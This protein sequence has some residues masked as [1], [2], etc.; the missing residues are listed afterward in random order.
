MIKST[1]RS[2]G[3]F[4][5]HIKHYESSRHA[6]AINM[7]KGSNLKAQAYNNLCIHVHFMTA[8]IYTPGK[9]VSQ[10]P[11]L[12]IVSMLPLPLSNMCM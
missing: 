10:H 4:V 2:N 5:Y 9:K 8:L 6:D 7:I 11:V 12:S 3:E 1:T